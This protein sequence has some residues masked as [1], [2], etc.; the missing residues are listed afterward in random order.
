VGVL[1]VLARLLSRKVKD[2]ATVK[3]LGGLVLFPLTWA[4][5]GALSVVLHDYLRATLVRLPDE[6]AWAF[7]AAFAFAALGGAVA[8]RYLR[9]AREAARSAR[10]RLT[11]RLRQRAI[12]RLRKERAAICDELL[13][14]A[15]GLDLPGQ[16]QAD[17]RIV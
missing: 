4:L 6:P 3:L 16:V 17:G 5:A 14:L 12:E 13:A 7:C 1:W 10:V 2:E 9:L 8:L 15:E 11:R